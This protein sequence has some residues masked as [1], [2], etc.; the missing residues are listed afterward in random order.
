MRYS[1]LGMTSTIWGNGLKY[2]ARYDA[3]GRITSQ[4]QGKKTIA[5]AYDAAGNITKH[6]EIQG[7]K[8]YFLT[9]VLSRPTV[10]K[11]DGG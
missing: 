9:V 4:T 6:V 3:L 8:P 7:H 2:Q 10:R 11:G 1:A 5:Y